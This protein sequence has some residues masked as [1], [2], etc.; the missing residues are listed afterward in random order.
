LTELGCSTGGLTSAT[1][2]PDAQDVYFL[3]VPMSGG[4]EGS[5]GKTSAGSERAPAAPAC[6]P[7]LLAGCP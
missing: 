1:V 4:N 6:L 7:Q 2:T 5:Y 3:V